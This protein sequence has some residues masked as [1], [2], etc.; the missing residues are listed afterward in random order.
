MKIKINTPIK[1]IRLKCLDCCAGSGPEVKSC[2][3]ADCPLFPYRMGRRPSP[4]IKSQIFNAEPLP[5]PFCGTKKWYVREEDVI[6]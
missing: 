2:I 6:K 4:T 5:S 1:S 3:C